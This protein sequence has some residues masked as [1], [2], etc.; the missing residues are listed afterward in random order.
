M[1]VVSVA[2][3]SALWRKMASESLPI[4]LAEFGGFCLLAIETICL[5]L[6]KIGYQE[7]W[8]GQQDLNLRPGVPKTPHT[9]VHKKA[10]ASI[11]LIFPL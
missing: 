5:A 10:G 1:S 2:V 11:D 4:F 3:G 9:P 8:S 7:E 6:R